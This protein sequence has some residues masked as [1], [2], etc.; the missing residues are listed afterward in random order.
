MARATTRSEDICRDI[1]AIQGELIDLMSVLATPPGVPAPA[2]APDAAAVL[3]L[4]QRIDAY[5]KERI[6]TNRFVRPGGSLASAALDL[7]RTIVRRAER[8]LV[9]LSRAESIEPGI[10]QYLNRLSDLLYVMARVDEQREIERLVVNVVSS[11]SAALR[12]GMPARPVLDLAACD[13]LV[14]AGMRK[15]RAIGVPMVL[16]VV[17][18]SG[19]L[20]QLRRMDNALLVSVELAAHKAQTAAM[21]RMPTAELARLAQPGAQFFGIDANIPNLTLVAGGLPLMLDGAILGAVG[22]SGG[23]AEQ[24]VKVAEAMA[25]ALAS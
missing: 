3:R 12:S 5:E 17:D 2:Q 8:R 20:L 6:A 4:E 16:A 25:A 11:S 24:D 15:A 1:L 18:G 10:E 21:V 13:V 14:E 22:A 19:V 7:A 23:S 9:A